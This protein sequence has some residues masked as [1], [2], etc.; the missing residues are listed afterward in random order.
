MRC[1]NATLD[2]PITNACPDIVGVEA[3]SWIVPRKYIKNKVITDAECTFDI[4]SEVIP[5]YVPGDLPYKPTSNGTKNAYGLQKFVKTTEFFFIE[6]TTL[7]Q[8]QILQLY[9]DDWV[10][11]FKDNNGQNLVFGLE[12]GLNF[13]TSSQDFNS[14]DTHGGIVVVMEETNVNTPM[15]FTADSTLIWIDYDLI[16]NG[17]IADGGAVKL[18][19]DA[20]KVGYVRL[21][22]GTLLTT[23]AGVI[24]TIYSGVGGAITYYIPKDSVIAIIENSGLTGAITTN[25]AGVISIEG[26]NAITGITAPYS[27]HIHCRNM[28]VLTSLSAPLATTLYAN[29][30]ALTAKS[31]GDFLIAASINNPTEAGTADFGGGT[32]A[33]DTAID[34]YLIT[35]GTTLAAILVV[36]ATWTITLNEA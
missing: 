8:K 22:N 15:L 5:V 12:S 28:A 35:Q 27:T 10:Q 1:F 34:A 7:S 13:K 3:N 32:S 31:I 24:D 9:N 2:T 14:L 16:Y 26:S 4:I 20:D 33:L 36:L 23:V 29:S 6:N 19:I 21:P 17:T 30:S 18:T 25:F 11:V